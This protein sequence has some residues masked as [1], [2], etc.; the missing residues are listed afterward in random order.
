MTSFI[1]I[2]LHVLTNQIKL[3]NS[4][5]PHATFQTMPIISSDNHYLTLLLVLPIRELGMNETI[6]WCLLMHLTSFACYNI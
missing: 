1:Y 5:H 2:H 6:H 4:H 3:Q